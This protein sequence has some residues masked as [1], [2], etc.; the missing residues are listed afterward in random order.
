MRADCLLMWCQL[1]RR[2]SALKHDVNDDDKASSP[3]RQR[4][5]IAII[6][7]NDDRKRNSAPMTSRC[8]TWGR[9]V[10]NHCGHAAPGQ[11]ATAHD[12]ADDDDDDDHVN[13]IS[14]PDSA[15]PYPCS[16]SDII[17]RHHTSSSSSL[18][19]TFFCLRQDRYTA[20]TAQHTCKLHI[21]WKN[22]ND[23]RYAY[24]RRN[25]G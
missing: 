20:I 7:N 25:R 15:A 16:T 5:C 13:S 6:D 22:E 10:V 11:V 19:L 9:D 4:S 18:A 3:Q 14:S 1:Q 23:K 2:L 8:V 12:N 17:W 24:E 21:R